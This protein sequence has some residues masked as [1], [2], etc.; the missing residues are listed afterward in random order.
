MRARLAEFGLAGR[1]NHLRHGAVCL[2]LPRVDPL[3]SFPSLRDVWEQIES[4][5]S[6]VE[7]VTYE[8]AAVEGWPSGCDGV[9]SR[10]HVSRN[11]EQ[12]ATAPSERSLL[13]C[14]VLMGAKQSISVLV[15]ILGRKGFPDFDWPPR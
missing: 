6:A 8:L 5:C 11:R 14:F 4:V 12:E 3:R 7:C 13:Y 2:P 1:P 15:Q 9:I 10:A